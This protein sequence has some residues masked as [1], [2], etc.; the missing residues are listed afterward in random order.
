VFYISNVIA[1]AGLELPP[2]DRAP[3]VMRSFDQELTLCQ[4]Y[5][6]SSWDYGTTPGTAWTAG[7]DQ[8]K[9]SHPIGDFSTTQVFPPMRIAGTLTIYDAAGTGAKVTYFDN[10]LGSWANNGGLNTWLAK[11]NSMFA[12]HTVPNSRFTNFGFKIDARL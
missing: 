5:F 7:F 4:R 1:L 12:Q 11:Q 6:R 8:I 9:F 2:S 10:A 3:L